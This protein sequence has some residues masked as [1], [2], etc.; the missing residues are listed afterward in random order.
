MLARLCTA[1]ARALRLRWVFL[2]RLLS[3]FDMLSFLLFIIKLGRTHDHTHL[4]LSL[5][6]T[7]AIPILFLFLTI[8]QIAR[9]HRPDN[10]Q[11]YKN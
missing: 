1:W 8:C 5:R 10:K 6:V 3:S 7:L 4:L 9:F 2:L 11:G